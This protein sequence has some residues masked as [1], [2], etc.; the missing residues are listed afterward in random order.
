M[1]KEKPFKSIF[2]PITGAERQTT[3]NDHLHLK[4]IPLAH[5]RA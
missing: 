1:D 2:Y 3:N 4:S 5:W